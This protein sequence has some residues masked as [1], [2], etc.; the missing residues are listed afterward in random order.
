MKSF[1]KI[2]IGFFFGCVFITLVFAYCFYDVIVYDEWK[3]NEYVQSQV[4]SDAWQRISDQDYLG[5]IA[6]YKNL[7]DQQST[8]DS[9]LFLSNPSYERFIFEGQL[10]ILYKKIGDTKSFNTSV[11]T[12]LSLSEEALGKAVVNESE[13]FFLL[14]RTPRIVK[15]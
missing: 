2:G 14:L 13:L 11:K 10:A 6:L 12:C 1:L 4:E 5:A 15:L 8:D 9:Y 7:I 3:D